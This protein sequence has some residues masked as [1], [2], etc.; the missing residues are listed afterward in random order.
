MRVPGGPG[1]R[2]DDSGAVAGADVPVHYDPL[3]A[4]LSAWAVDRPTAI[5]RMTRA[6]AEYDV[7][8]IKTTIPFFRWL[9]ADP[10]FQAGRFD[11]TF[12][13]Q[14]L[15]RRNGRP[16]QDVPPEDEH[17]AIVAAAVHA[18]TRT[19]SA[20]APAARESRWKRHAR[21]QGLR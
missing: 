4:K 14:A 5:A 1:I 2:R 9:L 3:I 13:D 7:R 20:A 16:F 11:T 6:L 15:A 19:M 10:D 17:L 8:G 18:M 21:T 12:I